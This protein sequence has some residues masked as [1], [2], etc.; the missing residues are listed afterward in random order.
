MVAHSVIYLHSDQ[1]TEFRE[2]RL[3]IP[4]RS[5]CLSGDFN[6]IIIQDVK[7]IPSS[8]RILPKL[9]FMHHIMLSHPFS[10]LS[11]HPLRKGISWRFHHI[12]KSYSW[13]LWLTIMPRWMRYHQIR[14]WA[15]QNGDLVFQCR[16]ALMFFDQNVPGIISLPDKGTANGLSWWGVNCQHCYCK[17][18]RVCWTVYDCFL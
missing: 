11:P 9:V 18:Q 8:H 4:L 13:L 3:L 5:L 14:S 12:L 1:L 10:Y 6:D 15:L 17:L 16:L 7:S 2:P